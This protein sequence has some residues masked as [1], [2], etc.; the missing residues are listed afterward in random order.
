[1]KLALGRTLYDPGDPMGNRWYMDDR[2]RSVGP[3]AHAPTPY[4]NSVVLDQQG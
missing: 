4:S 3:T 2:Y 1:M